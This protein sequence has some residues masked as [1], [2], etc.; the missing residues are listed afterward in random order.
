MTSL[1]Q[2]ELKNRLTEYDAL[3]KRLSSIDMLIDW[4]DGS[5]DYQKE[6]GGV[7]MTIDINIVVNN[8]SR[9]LEL[10]EAQAEKLKE[11][12]DS[13]RCDVRKRMEEL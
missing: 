5:I 7:F 4:I 6:M 11:F 8:R 12:L 13:C 2:K 9:C 1:E 10:N 3:G